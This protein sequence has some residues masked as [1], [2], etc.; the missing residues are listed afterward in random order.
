MEVQM[1]LTWFEEFWKVDTLNRSLEARECGKM[2][3][4]GKIVPD[5]YNFFVPPFISCR[6]RGQ[7]FSTFVCVSFVT[8]Y[9]EGWSD[10]LM[11]FF[12]LELQTFTSARTNSGHAYLDI[13]PGCETILAA[14]KKSISRSHEIGQPIRW[15]LAVPCAEHRCL[16]SDRSGHVLDP[17]VRCRS[18]LFGHV[19][20]ILKV[21][22]QIG[23]S[24]TVNQCV[25]WRTVL[26][27]NF[28]PRTHLPTKPCGATFHI[29]LDL[30][31]CRLPDPSWRR[32]P[33][34]PRKRWLDQLRRDNSTP[35]TDLWRRAVSHVW[36]LGGDATVLDDY[37]LTTTM[38][39][40][41]DSGLTE[42][43]RNA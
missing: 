34:H 10:T 12:V 27:S 33:G 6:D 17:I 30:S 16:L 7:S 23:K 35:P 15:N 14:D 19:T 36:T 41:T 26:M 37:A 11:M 25:P 39:T 18:P 1:T 13:M 42:R 3:C 5:I 32:C 24:D 31:L 28:I 9:W 8:W 21:W 40:T 20:A 4:W 43:R 2:Y 29:G 22:R 38:T